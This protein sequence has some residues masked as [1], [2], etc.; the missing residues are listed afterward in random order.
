LAQCI[1]LRSLSLR[2]KTNIKTKQKSSKADEICKVSKL[3]DTRGNANEKMHSATINS[4]K[5]APINE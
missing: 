1:E 5:A 3:S 4:S 2:A